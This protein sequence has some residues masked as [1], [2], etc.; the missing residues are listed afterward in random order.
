[1]LQT[2]Y[3]ENIAVIEKSAIDFSSGLNV[4]TGETGAGKSIII[5]AI[6]AIMGQRTSR[7]IIRTGASSAFVSAQFDNVNAAVRRKLEEFGFESDEDEL[8]LQRTL[9]ASGKSTC[10]INGRPATA[11]ML[12]EIAAGLINIHG[13]HESYELFSPETH[14]D[15]ID[16]YGRLIP[17]LEDYKEKYKRYLI[18]QKKLNEANSDESSRLSEI[19]LLSFQSKELFDADIQIGEEEALDSE[20]SA[21]M[22]FEKLSSL[23]NRAHMLLS[24]EDNSGCEL[25][26]MAANA[27]QNAANYS[28]DYEEISNTLTDVY[29]NLRDCAELVSDA[30]DNLESDPERLE[31]IEERLDLINRLTRK[32]NCTADELPALAEQMQSRLEELLNYDRNRDE[33]IAACKA[34]REEAEQS[35]LALSNNR[36]KTAAEFAEKVKAEMSFLNMPN[37]ELVPYFEE[38]A[39]SPKG[40]DKMELLISANPG[41]TPRPV[42]KIASGGELSR[43]ML[44]IKT[45]LAGTDTVDTLIFDEVDTGISGSAAE[46]VGLKL[47]EVSSECQVLCVTHQAQIAALADHHYLIKKQVEQGRTFTEVQPLD[48]D[49]RVNELARIIGGVNITDA[50][51]SHA[52]DMLHIHDH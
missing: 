11:A 9:S 30:L 41:E 4:L 21:L 7:D 38:S 49:G 16:R 42:A 39:L 23:L 3:I 46:K 29:Y 50:A 15:Y 31:E 26:D 24:G 10:K 48:H 25:V 18:L 47:R 5:D 35:A 28:A 22:N 12:R 19:D 44:A 36:R 33:L 8:L 1:M 27:M 13:Q 34:A 52:E 20:R 40:M 14:I 45:V 37:V 51:R 17:A 2:L 43:M 32:Y 6:N